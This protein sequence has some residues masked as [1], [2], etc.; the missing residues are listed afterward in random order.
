MRS[1][2]LILL[3]YC[4]GLHVTSACQSC[5]VKLIE[6]RRR[7]ISVFKRRHRNDVHR[8][9][10]MMITGAMDS[11]L[12]RAFLANGV[13]ATILNFLLMRRLLLEIANEAEAELG[14]TGGDDEEKELIDIIVG[15]STEQSASSKDDSSG[16]S[17]EITSQSMIIAIGFYKKWISPLLPPACRFLPTCSQYGVQAI[18]KYG[19]TKGV[20][21]TAWRLARCT[22][23][24]GRG[25]DPPIWPPVAYNHGS[26]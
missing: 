17:T 13:D 22:P 18:E 26:Y 6:N 19:P 15:D 23:L 11:T 24:G 5:L 8:H 7:S 3:L 14:P 20:I 1:L 21:L 25:Y 16:E 10:M 9:E 4:C 2:A 12:R